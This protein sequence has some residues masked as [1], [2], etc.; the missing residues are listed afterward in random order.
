MS[1]DSIIVRVVSDAGRNRIEIDAKSTCEEL[2]EII[3]HKIGIPAPKVKFYQDMGHKKA[4]KYSATSSLKRA[5]ITNGTQI[6]IP[7]KN[8]K[9]QDIIHKPKKAEEHEEEK[10]TTSTPGKNT[11]THSIDQVMENDGETIGADGRSEHCKH[12]AH[13]KCLHCLG[14]DKNNFQNIAYQCNHAKDQM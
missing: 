12:G 11:Y 5:G 14:V 7:A 2:Q 10:I 6:F 8:A 3:A 4:F 13:S 1:G 9:M